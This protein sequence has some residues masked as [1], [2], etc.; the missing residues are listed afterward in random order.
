MAYGR[1]ESKNRKMLSKSS[2]GIVVIIVIVV[3]MMTFGG[4]AVA[5]IQRD[6]ITNT[7]REEVFS[8]MDNN[9]YDD[10]YEG[11]EGPA[12]WAALGNSGWPIEPYIGRWPQ[13]WPVTQ[14]IHQS[15]EGDIFR[16][17][18]GLQLRNASYFTT[19][20]LNL[21]LGEVR[22]MVDPIMTIT[23]L[24]DFATGDQGIPDWLGRVYAY[25]IK[26]IPTNWACYTDYWGAN[27]YTSHRE[28]SDAT[29]DRYMIFAL[30]YWDNDRVE[31]NK[32]LKTSS[33]SP[34]DMSIQG[35]DV[36]DNWN[37][38][39]LYDTVPPYDDGVEDAWWWS[40]TCNIDEAAS[41]VGE[42][43]L[44]RICIEKDLEYTDVYGD[45]SH[46]VIRD[47]RLH[48]LKMGVTITDLKSNVTELITR[49]EVSDYNGGFTGSV[50]LIGSIYI[51]YNTP[52]GSSSSYNF[53]DD[54]KNPI[55]VS[56]NRVQ[57][58]KTRKIVYDEIA[59]GGYI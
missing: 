5:Q 35:W 51:L 13:V 29:G 8:N 11:T 53:S 32:I 24:E 4:Q 50:M 2:K 34:H 31:G 33:F 20:T 52:R 23:T 57:E 10:Y 16:F 43:A 44:L 6:Y 3:L 38:S 27:P 56:E 41:L 15:S 55:S 47:Y 14:I 30:D 46:Y 58:E 12:V 25:W 28:L 17:D 45:G 37:Q 42:D 1:V 36:H 54:K 39:N 21:T 40:P 19:Y 26:P 18:Y 9:I 22:D 59:K 48:I 49:S 7:W